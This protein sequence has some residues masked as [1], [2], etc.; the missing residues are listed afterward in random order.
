[1]YALDVITPILPLIEGGILN[2]SKFVPEVN[3]LHLGPNRFD[4]S[5]NLLIR[6]NVLEPHCS[7]LYHLSDVLVLDLNVLRPTKEN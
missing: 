4:N 5:S 3:K 6:R 7:L 1:M 2:H